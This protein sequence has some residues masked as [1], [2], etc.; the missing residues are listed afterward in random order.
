MKERSEKINSLITQQDLQQRFFTFW[1]ET[2]LR[3]KRLKDE[4]LAVLGENLPKTRLSQSDKDICNLKHEIPQQI[5]EKIKAYEQT[6]SEIE[7][8]QKELQQ[9]EQE[10]SKR[11]FQ[12]KQGRDR[13]HQKISNLHSQTKDSFRQT[14]NNMVH[15]AAVETMI[16]NRYNNKRDAKEYAAGYLVEQLQGELKNTIKQNSEDLKAEIDKFLETYEKVFLKLPKL[17]VGSVSIPFDSKGAFLGGLAGAG[18]VGALALWATSLGNLGAYI[19]VA[20]FVSLLSALGISISGGVATVVSFV[21][22]IGGPITLGIGLIAAAT[23]IGLSL[24]GESW[25]RRLA[26]K[27]VSHFEEQQVL[28]K[29]LQGVDEYWQDTGKAFD[30]GA[31]AVEKS[32][33]DYIQHLRELCSNDDK[34][35]REYVEYILSVLRELANFFTAIPWKNHT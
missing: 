25:Q 34:A 5:A 28:N 9:L 7:Q 12:V 29:F 4:L 32:F 23:M 11:V 1:E 27:I 21:A 30:K 18:G 19:L 17:N 35:S 6:K 3:W 22:G 33:Q 13:V 2:P 24:F 10:E 8:R 14:Y 16:R 31:D 15:L 26:R 20:K